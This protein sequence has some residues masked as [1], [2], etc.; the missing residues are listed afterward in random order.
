M[1][2]MLII[3]SPLEIGNI[4]DKFMMA[5]IKMQI[6]YVF[7]TYDDYKQDKLYICQT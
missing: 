3:K 6:I 7:Y 2:S 4:C 1:F 5:K